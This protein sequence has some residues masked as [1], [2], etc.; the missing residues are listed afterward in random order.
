MRPRNSSGTTCDVA[1]STRGQKQC[2]IRA[3][4]RSGEGYRQDRYKLAEKCIDIC[5]TFSL[6]F[7]RFSLSR[8]GNQATHRAVW[9]KV[10]REA[11][12]RMIDMVEKET[13]GPIGLTG[14][15][16]SASC[17]G[18]SDVFFAPFAERPEAR[19]RREASAG[20]ICSECDSMSKCRDY[21]RTNREL[22]YWGGESESERAA[23]GFPPT[24][25]IIG[26]KRVAEDRA[27]TAMARTA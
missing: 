5:G 21:A 25:P 3:V 4:G 17:A 23:A 16:A 26:R 24:T 19:V 6:W 8:K 11:S 15:M 27:R 10:P 22:G 13:I 7:H 20:V 1:R 18:H 14:W 12:M 2:Q 9:R